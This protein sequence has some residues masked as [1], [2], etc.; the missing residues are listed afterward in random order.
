MKKSKIAIIFGVS[1]QDG[2]Y[3][4]H[5]LINKGY[6]IIGITRNKSPKNLYRLKKLNILKKIRIVKGEASDFN[7]CKKIISTKINEIYFLS[8]YSSVTRLI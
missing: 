1:G 4:S 3:L 2:S 8:G 7:F 5:L 6:K